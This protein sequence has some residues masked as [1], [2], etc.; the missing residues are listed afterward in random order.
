M[1]AMPAAGCFLHLGHGRTS[2]LTREVH[3]R[4]RGGSCASCAPRFGAQRKPEKPYLR[5]HG[6]IDAYS[7]SCCLKPWDCVSRLAH[8]TELTVTRRVGPRMSKLG[9]HL[10]FCFERPFVPACLHPPSVGDAF[11]AQE[12]SR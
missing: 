6:C 8:Q 10:N 3:L 12:R 11:L 9:G 1:A 7:A 5:G 2:P 4:G